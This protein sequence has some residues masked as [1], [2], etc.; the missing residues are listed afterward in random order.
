[1]KLLAGLFWDMEY[2]DT[3]AI[4]PEMELAKLALVTSKDEEEE[5]A[6]RP[7]TDGSN[8][9]A[10]TDA[11]LVDDVPL[12][13]SPQRRDGS[14]LSPGSILGKRAREAG[15]SVAVATDVDVDM[16]PPQ[17]SVQPSAPPLMKRKSTRMPDST[18][19]MMFG[20]S[21]VDCIMWS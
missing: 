15:A 10:D 11:T 6:D 13:T 12:V 19:T 9:S 18:S 21:I 5:D 17:P 14:P 3:P 2:H 16:A 8:G 1:V 4:T 7:P 20:E